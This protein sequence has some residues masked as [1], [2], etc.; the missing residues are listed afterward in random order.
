MTQITPYIRPIPKYF[1]EERENIGSDGK[2]IAV[3]RNLQNWKTQLFSCFFFHLP[4]SENRRIDPAFFPA[5]FPL[6]DLQE[7]FLLP[8]CKRT[9]QYPF[10]T[11]S[12]ILPS[13]FFIDP[14]I[15]DHV[16]DPGF[17]TVCQLFLSGI[18]II[19][20]FQNR[21]A[22]LFSGRTPA[23]PFDPFEVSVSVPL[24][25]R[26]FL[27]LIARQIIRCH[28]AQVGR[29]DAPA[30]PCD[31]YDLTDI[32]FIMLFAFLKHLQKTHSLSFFSHPFHILFIKLA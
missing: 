16:L 5:V 22:F 4:A 3:I 11:K 8:F 2:S 23:Y 27:S 28:H 20:H 32:P 18:F 21:K 19:Q 17:Q 1:P 9:Y 14:K 15:H 12:K 10:S 13:A 30:D 6:Q 7:F 31:P 24:Q 29:T 25:R 26:C